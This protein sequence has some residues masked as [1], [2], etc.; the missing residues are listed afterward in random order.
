MTTATLDSTAGPGMGVERPIAVRAY[1]VILDKQPNKGAGRPTK[2]QQPPLSRLALVFDCETRIDM[3]Q[4]LTVGFAVVLRSDWRRARHEAAGVICFVD[5]AALST[6]ERLTIEAWLSESLGSVLKRIGYEGKRIDLPPD[7]EIEYQTLETFRE[8]FYTLAH[9]GKA[10]VVGFNLPFDLSRL[11]VR[12]SPTKNKRGHIFTLI[13]HTDSRGRQSTKLRHPR[14]RIM[15]IDGHRALIQFTG[16]KPR[17]D[18][19]FVDLKTLGDALTG[20]R[21]T[22]ATACETFGLPPKR[23]HDHDGRVTRQLLDY[24]LNDALVTAELYV[25]E[26]EEHQRHPIAKAPHQIYSEATIGK[27]YLEAMGLRL[28]ELVIDPGLNLHRAPDEPPPVTSAP[29]E[30]DPLAT[31]L[32]YTTTTY[33]GGRTECRVR[34]MITPVA[35]ADYASMYSSCNCLMDLWE[36]LTAERIRVVDAT[37]DV[38]QLLET[39]QPEDLYDP[40][41]WRQLSAIIELVPDGDVLPARSRFGDETLS[42]YGI[43]VNP[44]SSSRPLWYTL[45][46]CL[47]SKLRTGKTPRLVRA[48]RFVPEGRQ[49]LTPVKLRGQVPIDPTTDDFFR[50]AIVERRA[51]KQGLPPYDRLSERDRDWLQQFIKILVNATAYGIYMQMDRQDGET[52]RVRAHGLTTIEREISGPEKLG[53]Y[54]FPPL[55]T[56]ITAGARVRPDGYRLAGDCRHRDRWPLTMPWGI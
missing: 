26:V 13:S 38:Q 47:A 29:P 6:P 7:V 34:R 56:L 35:Y 45:A 33:F 39:V 8:S 51:V 49:R 52:A 46:D 21:H 20:E 53:P 11:A 54:C 42:T 44:L 55:A 50:E 17:Y 19:C 15:P 31:V 23:E 12:S 41:T 18:G 32:G 40:T 28:P 37:A 16:T 25:A 24:A 22:L 36:Y 14:I 43:G 4:R 1:P 3:G 9:W 30:H 48:L 10:A 5:E 27:A 2:P